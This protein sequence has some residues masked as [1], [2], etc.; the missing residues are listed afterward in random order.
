M[1]APVRPPPEWPELSTGREFQIGSLSQFAGRELSGYEALPEW[2]DPAEIPPDSVREVRKQAPVRGT[3]E[4]ED[5]EEEDEINFNDFFGD[6]APQSRATDDTVAHEEE[7]GNA[8]EYEDEDEP[9][10]DDLDG[11]FD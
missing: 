4:P 7:E 11:F 2:A 5:G 8:D 9:E 10:G 3:A 1:L 6:D